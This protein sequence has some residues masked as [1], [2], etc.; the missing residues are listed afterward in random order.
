MNSPQPPDTD[1]AGRDGLP[2]AASPGERQLIWTVWLAYGAFYFCRTNLAAALPGIESELHLDKTDMGLVLLGS[3]LAYAVGQ[4][5]NGQFAE[6]IPARRMLALGMFGSAALNV[7]FGFGTGLYFFLFVWAMNGY[8]QSM[9]WTPCVRVIG[10]WIPIL[11]RGRAIGIVGTGYQVTAGL[12]YL[13]SGVAVWW[14]GWRGAVWVPPVI[15]AASALVMLVFLRE[16][17]QEHDWRADPQADRPA[18]RRGPGFRHTLRV[19][20][21]N[22]ALWLLALSLGMLNACRYGFFDWGVSHLVAIERAETQRAEINRELAA[23]TSPGIHQRLSGLLALDLVN[24]ESQ[25]QVKALMDDGLLP[26]VKTASD[27]A[28]VLK[29][30]LNYAVL[31]IGAIMGSFLAGWAS[32]RFFGG[33]RAPVICGLLVALGCLTLAYDP[34]ARTSFVA[35]VA[36]LFAVGFCIF[37][38]QVL[39][40]GTAPADLARDGTA[41]AAAGFVNCFGYFGAAVA[42]DLLTGYL[43]K[44]YGWKIAI[45]AWAGWAFAAAVTMAFL[46]NATGRSSPARH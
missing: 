5:V 13:V 22:P 31:P 6:R 9:G 15:L 43:A 42:G 20:L 18:A 38:P 16:S 2:S 1:P 41:A 29:S 46:W 21:A 39:L 12:T 45:Y 3:K 11:R 24:D 33:R 34:L 27:R 7:L 4:F 44:H 36:L 37:G 10:N 32:D 26:G 35:T 25:K 23:S 28:A 17:P 19:T 30:A 14:L 8:A 40:V